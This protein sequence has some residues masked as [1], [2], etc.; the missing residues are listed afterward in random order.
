MPNIVRGKCSHFGGPNDTGVSPSEGL[1]FIYEIDMA[2]RLFLPEQPPGTTGLAR[3]LNPARPYIAMRWDYDAPRQSKEELLNLVVLVRNPKNGKVCAAKP[4]DWGPHE[5]TDRIADLSPG[6]MERLELV[7]DDEV[8]VLIPGEREEPDAPSGEK[9]SVVISVGH[10]LK[11]RGASGVIDEVDEAC[12]VVPA[13]AKYLRERDCEVTEFFDTTSEDQE[14][15]LETICAFHNSR[16]AHDYDVSVHFNAYDGSA[17]GTECFY[18]SQHD[19]AARVAENIADCSG[20]ENRGAKDGSGLYFCRHT[21]AK[22]ILIEVAFCDS[23]LDA[24]L[25]LDNFNAI[26][27]SIADAILGY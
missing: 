8:E 4:S 11:I 5:D 18:Y 16:A 27:M 10:G 7:T 19:L 2:P 14:T 1:A 26:A 25:Y 24:R 15:N 6:I 23:E 17:N 12:K 13:V 3:R 21:N 9:P 20:M 22:S